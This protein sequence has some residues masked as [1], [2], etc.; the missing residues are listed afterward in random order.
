MNI[1]YIRWIAAYFLNIHFVIPFNAFDLLSIISVCLAISIA[2]IWLGQL[3][4]YYLQ[5]FYVI[6]NNFYF[7]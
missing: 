3:D 5:N 6:D 7:M 2:T 4:F 1:F